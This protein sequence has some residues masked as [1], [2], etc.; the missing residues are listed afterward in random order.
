MGTQVVQAVCA[1][2]DMEVVGG[3]DPLSP[4]GSVELEGVAIAPAFSDL[5]SALATVR[6][7]VLVD[8]TS[9][10]SVADNL[11]I[12]LSVGVD[13]VVGTTGLTPEKLA[14]LAA[15]AP[16]GTA[17]FH[18]PNFTLGAVLMMAFATKAARYFPD[19]EVIE[20]HHNNKLDA[21]S[22]TAVTTALNMAAVRAEA[23]ISSAA[24]GAESELPGR[25]GARGTNV[26]GVPVHSVRSNGYMAHQEVIFGSTGET[27][28]IRHD[29]IDRACYMPGVL[30][31]LREV[32]KL[33]GLV[34]GLDKLLDL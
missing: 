28:T 15:C 17:L 27:L 7:D 31:A 19:V 20:F 8:F 3:Y 26:N 6:P 33:S 11:R 22:G 14:E 24:P 9:P 16:E 30:L 5:A 12:A 10:A 2:D 4:T 1:Q 32:G 13:C 34:I 18:A 29:S 25:G 21:P 23:H